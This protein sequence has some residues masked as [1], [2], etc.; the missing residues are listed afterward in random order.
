MAILLVN[1]FIVFFVWSVGPAGYSG[2]LVPFALVPALVP[3]GFVGIWLPRV[4]GAL[5][6]VAYGLAVVAEANWADWEFAAFGAV[7]PLGTGATLYVG[8]LLLA[9]RRA[10]PRGRRVQAG[11]LLGVFALLLV[12]YL[13]AG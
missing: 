8:L 10:E 12:L 2:S 5:A 11:L 7:Y 9:A 4:G 6:L 13:G 1:A 3:L